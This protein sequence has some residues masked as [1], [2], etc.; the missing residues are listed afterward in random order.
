MQNCVR[1]FQQNI[2]PDEDL[3]GVAWQT[4]S[5][6]ASNFNSSANANLGS[7]IPLRLLYFESETNLFLNIDAVKDIEISCQLSPAGYK[8]AFNNITRYTK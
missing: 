3:I 2:F 6:N 5:S 4:S 7:G 1:D 8:K